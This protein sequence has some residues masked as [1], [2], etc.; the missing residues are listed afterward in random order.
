[1][2][3]R[4]TDAS[5]RGVTA[6]ERL[7]VRAAPEAVVSALRDVLR[8][9]AMTEYAVV[10]HGRDMAAAGSPGFAAWTLIFGNPAAG[11]KLLARDLAAT[12]DIPLRI[13][14]IAGESGS[15][16]IVLRDMRSLLSNDLADLAEAFTQVLHSLAAEARERAVGG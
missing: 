9:R 10:D 7:S 15:S 5:P 16:E 8:S 6:Y 13:A 4:P 14:V 11:A 3:P 2:I 1:M 12:V